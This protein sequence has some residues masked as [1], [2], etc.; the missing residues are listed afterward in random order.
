ME[1]LLQMTFLK[2]FRA[3]E[4]WPEEMTS[5]LS[6]FYTIARNLVIDYYRK[7]KEILIEDKEEE[8]GD[9]FWSRLAST[10]QDPHEILLEKNKSEIL[11]DLL[12]QLPENYRQV[13]W[14]RFVDEKSNAEIA[15]IVGKTEMN[16]RQIQV[17]AL[18]KIRSN[19]SE[20]Y[21]NI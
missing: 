6:Y 3:K 20:D 15:E 18:R 10:E 7:H 11:K 8:N 12:S 17:R 14:L 21:D 5:P 4:N 19:F 16:I 1:D 2:A 9:S 13:M